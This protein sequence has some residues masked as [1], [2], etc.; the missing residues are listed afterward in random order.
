VTGRLTAIFTAASSS[1]A[2]K[3]RSSTDL[4][5]RELSSRRG[6][7]AWRRYLRDIPDSY[8]PSQYYNRDNPLSYAK[9]AEQLIDRI[10]KL[11]C[12]VGSVGSGGSMSGTCRYLRVLF[13]ELHAIGVDTP[14]SVLFG[15]PSGRLN[16]SGLG[17]NILPTNVDHCQFDEV[18]WLPPSEAF[19]A[20]HELHHEHGLFMGPTSGAAYRVAEWWSRNNPDKTVVAMFP[21]EGHR[22]VETVYDQEWLQ[23]V[24][25]RAAP[26]RENPVTVST[27][28]QPMTGWS[29]F[30][31]NRRT[32]REVLA[33]AS[34]PSGSRPGGRTPRRSLRG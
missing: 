23:T 21:D 11:D 14:N 19:H 31:W 4:P 28:T 30:S 10:G 27:P 2:P 29:R 26:V 32:L 33:Q 8:W 5:P 16:L 25:D 22:Y 9:I 13:P 18:H 34:E 15:Q 7:I 1:L 24:P 6:S 17:G 20:T 3:S 12:L